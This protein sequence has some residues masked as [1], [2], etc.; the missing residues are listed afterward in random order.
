MCIKLMRYIDYWVGIPLCFLLSFFNRFKR[1]VGL[2]RKKSR[3]KLERIL[4]VKLSEIGAIILSYPL[5]RC[6]SKEYPNAEFFFLTFEKNRDVF[7]LWGEVVKEESVLTINEDSIWQFILD[8]FRVIRKIR[9]ERIDIA[10]DLELF[11]RFSAI[12]TYLSRAY[13]RVGFYRYTFEGL[14]RG[15]LLTHNIQY[16]PLLHISKSYL[17]LLQTIK[18]ESKTTPELEERVIEEDIFLPNPD[19]RLCLAE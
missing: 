10:F 5:L 11:S 15:N 1:I 16:N 14:Y 6:L 13:K 12:L 4:L 9:K 7:K 18:K 3:D 19:Q 2:K 8:A 17:S